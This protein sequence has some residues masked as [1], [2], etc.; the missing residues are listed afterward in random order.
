[1]LIVRSPVRISLAGGGTDLPSYYT[2]FGGNVLSTTL[3]KYFYVLITE[4]GGGYTQVISA[5]FQTFLHVPDNITTGYSG[6]NDLNLPSTVLDHF[7][8][9]GEEQIFIASEVPP[10]TGLG[11][12][13]AVTVGLIKAISVARK[14]DMSKQAIAE[15]ASYIEIEK[16]NAPIGKQ[17]QYAS[18]FG[19]LNFIRFEEQQVTVEPLDIKPDTYRELERNLMLFYTGVS[20]Q[21]NSILRQ[22][23]ANTDQNDAQVLTSLHAIKQAAIDLRHLLEKGQVE[24]VGEFLDE[25]WQR[26]KRL[27]KGI[28]NATIDAWYDLARRN[29]AGGGKITGAGGGGFL[30]LYCPVE[31]QTQ[32]K[33]ALAPVGLRYIGTRFEQKGVHVVLNS[34]DEA[35]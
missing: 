16:L 17:D 35:R 26:K 15:L 13:S 23:K 3:N 31:N 28:T 7:G 24:S 10:G 19:G 34:L 30:L 11:S 14:L 18:A 22:Q 29:G 33:K 2:R 4:T 6:G 5:D 32:V 25:N 27:S 12:S 1:M 8:Y 9:Q 21:A 20:R